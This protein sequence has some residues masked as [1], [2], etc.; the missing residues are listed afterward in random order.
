MG[1][2]IGE[3][4]TYAL[5]HAC[6][7]QEKL[8]QTMKNSNPEDEIICQLREQTELLNQLLKLYKRVY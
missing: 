7:K 8:N 5:E 3:T 1:T 4:I 6:Q 2:L